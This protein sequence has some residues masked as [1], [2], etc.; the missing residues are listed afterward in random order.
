MDDTF[1]EAAARL[2]E[3]MQAGQPLTDADWERYE[4]ALIASHQR[5]MERIELQIRETRGRAVDLRSEAKD[6]ESEYNRY[7]RKVERFHEDEIIKHGLEGWFP[8]DYS[9]GLLTE[10]E[11][12]AEY[13]RLLKGS[14]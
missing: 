5:L 11:Y 12:R 10:E 8:Q 13:E 3:K 9:P 1:A 14:N 7:A 6:F 2:D 4:R